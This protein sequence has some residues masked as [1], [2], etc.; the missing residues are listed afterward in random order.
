[1]IDDP[2]FNRLRLLLGDDVFAKEV[3]N[4]AYRYAMDYSFTAVKK[5]LKDIYFK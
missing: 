5:E 4:S 1:M 3:S 2:R